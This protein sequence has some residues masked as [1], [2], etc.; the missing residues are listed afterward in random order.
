MN[1][2]QCIL[3]LNIKR[4]ERPPN[5]IGRSGS[6]N[7]EKNYQKQVE[8]VKNNDMMEEWKL[9][10]GKRWETVFRNKTGDTWRLSM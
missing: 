4:Y 2:F 6:V 10:Q 7:R 8:Q 3:P 1:C 9:K 5:T